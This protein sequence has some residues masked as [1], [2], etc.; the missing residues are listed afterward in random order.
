MVT[1]SCSAWRR[2]CNNH[3]IGLFVLIHFPN[4]VLIKLNVRMHSSKE[5]C[6]SCMFQAI[7]EFLIAHK[8]LA[9]I[10]S[11]PFKMQ[12]CFIVS[13]HGTKPPR[14]HLA[15]ERSFLE[16]DYIDLFLFAI[17]YFR[18]ISF[19]VHDANFKRK[20]SLPYRPRQQRICCSSV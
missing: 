20:R 1:L 11:F 18:I 8:F 17:P 5:I 10:F 3:L 4:L 19:Q 2:K 13:G 9:N 7:Y 16:A 12:N 15:V 14:H 6:R